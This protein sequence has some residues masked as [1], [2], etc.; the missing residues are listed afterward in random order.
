MYF[1]TIFDTVNLN[2]ICDT[3]GVQNALQNAAERLK[4]IGKDMKTFGMEINDETK[5]LVYT[6]QLPGDGKRTTRVYTELD[7]G[8]TRLMVDTKYNGD[9]GIELNTDKID[10]VPTKVKINCGVLTVEFPIKEKVIVEY[11]FT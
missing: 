9:Y 2:P 7:D 6:F 4:T 5:T 3:A 11:P 8:I 10:V 1:N